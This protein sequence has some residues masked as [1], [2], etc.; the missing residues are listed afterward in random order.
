[1]EGE[2]QPSHHHGCRCGH[3]LCGGGRGRGGG[4]GLAPA[5]LVWAGLAAGPRP[6]R[7]GERAVEATAIAAGGGGDDN[8]DDD[9]VGGGRG[10]REGAATAAAGAIVAGARLC[11][12]GGRRRR[13]EDG[14]DGAGRGP[15]AAVTQ[16]WRWREGHWSIGPLYI[17]QV[18]VASILPSLGMR[19]TIPESHLI[20]QDIP[21][22][23]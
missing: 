15:L 12:G 16:H 6:F 13:R 4:A 20:S 14:G 7:G 17:T 21:L 3:H 23:G 8:D 5:R 22:L 10:G 11:R 18:S 2:P 9:G 1:M 19:S